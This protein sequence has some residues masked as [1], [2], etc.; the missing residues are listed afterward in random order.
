MALAVP[1]RGSRHESGVAQFLVVRRHTFSDMFAKGLIL[2]GMI[3]CI[4][5]S[6]RFL[7]AAKR[8]STGW[9]I[10]C[11]FV[12]VWPVFIVLHFS[13]AWRPMAIWLVGFIIARVGISLMSH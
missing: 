11:L 4:A 10:G 3:I 5:G 2:L 12:F 1:L 13:K 9:F 8:V 6:I 7:V